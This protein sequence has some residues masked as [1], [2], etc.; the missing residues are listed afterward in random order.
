MEQQDSQ[1][2]S[3]SIQT[4][5]SFNPAQTVQY[6]VNGQETHIFDPSFHHDL[7]LVETPKSHRSQIDSPEDVSF[8][9]PI[10]KFNTPMQ[11]QIMTPNFMSPITNTKSNDMAI[12]PDFGLTPIRK[13]EFA[14]P[15]KRD[16]VVKQLTFTQKSQE[17]AVRFAI[18]SNN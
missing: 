16:K 18:Y 15:K 7:D 14:K 5:V 12:S 8:V 4:E 9:S 10:A 6:E 13:D 2:A 1:R 11:R 3:Q 17:D